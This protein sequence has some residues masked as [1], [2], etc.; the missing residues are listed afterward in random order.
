MA[1]G[2]RPPGAGERPRTRASDEIEDPS[3]PAA[4]EEQQSSEQA[5][6]PDEPGPEMETEAAMGEAEAMPG[7]STALPEMHEAVVSA[8]KQGVAQ[9]LAAGQAISQDL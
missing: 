4:G 9:E 7:V 6:T 2:R 8:L 1:V 5:E 3:G